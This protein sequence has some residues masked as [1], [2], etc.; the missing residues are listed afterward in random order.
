[1]I[2]VDKQLPPVKETKLSLLTYSMAHLLNAFGIREH[3]N[4][5]LNNLRKKLK[6][7]DTLQDVGYVL[8]KLNEIDVLKKILLKENQI[9]C[10]DHL[11]KPFT[12]EVDPMLERYFPGVYG[13]EIKNRELLV[14]YFASVKLGNSMN[15]VDFLLY[16][17]LTN[18]V[19]E[20][21]KKKVEFNIVNV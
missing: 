4:P 13:S 20:N 17:H 15:E 12:T 9:L 16:E 8:K 5:G 18:D 3:D 2:K 7:V 6:V 10:F 14:D 19:K 11:N 1:M 21:I